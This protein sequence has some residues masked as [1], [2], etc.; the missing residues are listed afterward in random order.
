MSWP[1]LA[2]AEAELL[3]ALD[4]TGGGTCL[5]ASVA[6]VRAAPDDAPERRLA[7]AFALSDGELALVLLLAVAAMSEPGA[8]A[9]E[10]AGGAGGV[11]LWLARSLLPDLRLDQLSAQ[12]RLRRFH[13]V[14]APG[15]DLGAR[16][17]LPTAI[18]DWLLGLAAA[19]PRCAPYVAPVPVVAGL[20]EPELVGALAARLRERSGALPPL[21]QAGNE[22]PAALAAGLAALGLQPWLVRAA[23]LPADAEARDGLARAW[24][25]DAALNRAALLLDAGGVPPALA[26]GFAARIAGHVIIL[27]LEGAATGLRA[28][29]PLAAPPPDRCRRWAQAL[30]PD[31][32]VRLGGAVERVARQFRL[33]GATIDALVATHGA[34]LDA[35]GEAAGTLLWHLAARAEP[36]RGL[37]GASLVEPAR[38]WDE[39]VL[40]PSVEGALHRL[41]SHVRHAGRVFDDWGFATGFG[42]RG[43]G[44]AA[45]FAGPS[46]TGKTM[47]AEVLAHALD[48]RVLAIDLS[49]LISKFVGETSKNIA[50]AF[51]LAERSGAVM[52]WNE[53]DAIWGARGTVGQAVDRHINAEVGDLLQRIEAF[54]GFTIVTTNLRHAI[55]P[56][57]LRRFRFIVD[58]PMPSAHE[59][60]RIWQRAFPAAAPLDEVDFTVL[61]QQPLTGAAIRNI[62]LASAFQA[63]AAGRR[64]DRQ[65]IA[66]EL[67]D[68]LRK[69]DVLVPMIDWGRPQ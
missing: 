29:H 6:A 45:L 24:S 33:D 27:S 55:D 26:L 8:R 53:G 64:I 14:E 30:G 15:G 36:A 20:A 59:R 21:V 44:V 5:A 42:G 40:P 47:S 38:R 16:L 19:D 32:V 17:R 23:E 28:L 57:F 12:A 34:R 49:Q 18:Q 43:R 61:A 2:Q 54:E 63:A 69:S 4:A 46:G 58:F 56:A 52:V 65:L 62:A 66:A 39:L 11:P 37:P 51:D 67:A 50:A 3:A 1:L 25:R 31:R 9:L 68:E 13:L 60:L 48:L 22:E 35:A 41:E 10:A 7:D